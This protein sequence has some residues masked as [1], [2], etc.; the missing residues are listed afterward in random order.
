V[1]WLI[2]SLIPTTLIKADQFTGTPIRGADGLCQKCGPNEPGL[3]IGKISNQSSTEFHGY[4]D[5]ASSSKKVIRDVFCKGDTAFVSGDILQF[6]DYGYYYFVDR[7]GDTFRWKGEN[8]STCEVEA[9]ISNEVGLRDATAYGV[10][11]GNAEG[12]AGMVAITDPEGTVNLERLC[13]RLQKALPPYARPLFV[14][15]LK[16][17]DL[18]G[19][20]KLRKVDL[21]RDGFDPNV[22][23]DPIYY[24]HLGRSYERL[25]QEVF[26]NIVQNVI[27]F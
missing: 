5:E 10:V 26:E 22:V 20:C 1:P 15:L 27:R 25:T 7:T 8:V 4:V 18:T 11:V 21:Q 16:Q 9:I 12:R 19:T 13:E 23:N 24:L 14:R 17:A 2:A 6:D 3:C